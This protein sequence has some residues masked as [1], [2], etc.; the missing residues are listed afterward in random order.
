MTLTKNQKTEECGC[1]R[2][3][4][5]APLTRWLVLGV[6]LSLYGIYLAFIK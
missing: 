3:T 5:D 2:D 1:D 4:P 6:L